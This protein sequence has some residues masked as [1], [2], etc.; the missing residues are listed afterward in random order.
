[1]R[2]KTLLAAATLAAGIASS[3]AQSN[4]YSLNV[5]GYVSQTYDAGYHLIANPLNAT[6]NS[7]VSILP[8]V[9]SFTAVYKFTGGAFSSANTF[10][11]GSWTDPSMTLNPG[12][13]AFLFI[14]S[15]GN[16]TNVYV[17]EVLQGSLTNVLI[18]GYN[19]VGTKVPQAG[20][21][22]TTHNLQPAAFDASY[23]WDDP[24]NTYHSV[25]TFLF[26]SWQPQEPNIKVAEGFWYYNNTASAN[27]WSRN[28]T[29]SP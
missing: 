8:N 29:V 26:G 4:V 23:Q 14:P 2:T 24:N 10:L 17:G 6:N 28:F 22:T 1:M 5:V 7:I 13:G 3:V 21:V 25:N 11:F 27:A 12:E 15:G 16:Y 20:G 9:P 18:P 19:L